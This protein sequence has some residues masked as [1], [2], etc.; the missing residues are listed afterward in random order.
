MSGLA[1]AVPHFPLLS[2]NILVGAGESSL[3]RRL[4]GFWNIST[5]PGFLASGSEAYRAHRTNALSTRT[6]ST[7]APIKLLPRQTA[8]VCKLA[9][10]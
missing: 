3:L 6:S 2:S 4:T 8:A 9:L 7:S 1:G 5:D 10:T